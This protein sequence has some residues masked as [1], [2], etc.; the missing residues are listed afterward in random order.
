MDIG[1]YVVLPFL[2]VGIVSIVVSVAA[3][4]G[5]ILDMYQ[6]V[7]GHHISALT[8]LVRVVART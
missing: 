1:S 7:V 3:Q 2:E 6:V 8:N 4:N 5:S